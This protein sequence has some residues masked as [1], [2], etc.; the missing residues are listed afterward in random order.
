MDFACEEEWNNFA[1]SGSKDS[2]PREYVDF[3]KLM[4]SGGNINIETMGT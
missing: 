1:I 2:G 4:A 3:N